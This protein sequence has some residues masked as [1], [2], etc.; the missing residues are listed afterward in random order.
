MEIHFSIKN[1]KFLFKYTLHYSKIYDRFI[2]LFIKHNHKVS[3]SF[4]KEKQRY[5]QWRRK[6]DNWGGGGG[7]GGAIFIYSC[8]ALLTSFEI[9]CF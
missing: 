9:D 5:K 2:I 3:A 1:T 7:G 4:T 6:I 8:S